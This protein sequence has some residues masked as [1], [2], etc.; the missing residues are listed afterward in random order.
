M[1]RRFRGGVHPP[2]NKNATRDLPLRP[3]T[4]PPFVAIAFAQHIGKPASLMIKPGE[5]VLRGQKIADASGLVSVPVHSSVSGTA[6][7]VVQVRHPLG[8]MMDALRIDNDGQ[9]T[10]H[11]EALKKR[12]PASL[13]SQEIDRIVCEAGLVGMGGATFPTH[14]KLQPPAGKRI[15]VLLVN[16]AECEPYLTADDWLMRENAESI[17]RGAE[18]FARTVGTERIVVGME[19]NK[20]VALAS[21]KAAREKLSLGKVEILP[22]P[23]RYPQGAEK[24]LIYA[25][26]GRE[27]PSGGLPMDTGVLVHNVATCYAGYEAVAFSRPLTERVVTVTGP[28]VDRPAN[29]WVRI[30]T[31]AGHLLEECGF[32]PGRTR[33][34]LVGGPMMGMPMRDLDFAVGKGTNGIL[35]LTDPADHLYRPCI[36]CSRCVDGCPMGLY[37]CFLSNLGE[38]GD[39]ATAEQYNARDCIECGVCSYVCP[40]RRPIVQWIRLEKAELNRLRSTAK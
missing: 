40:S 35:A 6:K 33:K 32:A 20:P 30:G 9:D 1:L 28:G 25:L 13:S 11:P 18:L 38:A 17:L 19:N 23:V 2:E 31:M 24:Q 22:L 36:R 4:P 34:L 37:P 26:L 21:L 39:W 14:V 7:T 3:S 29:L 5:K 10:W 27:V 15:D 8:Y 12:D 16:A